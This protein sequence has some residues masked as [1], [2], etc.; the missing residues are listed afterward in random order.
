[1]I[2]DRG[3]SVYYSS[4]IPDNLKNIYG[5][6]MTS[7]TKSGYAVL[8]ENGKGTYR[9]PSYGFAVKNCPLEDIELKDWGIRCDK[10]GLILVY[11]DNGREQYTVVM[12]SN[13]DKK[14]EACYTNVKE[15]TLFVLD[16]KLILGADTQWEKQ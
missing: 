5:T 13:E 10:K 11:K 8:L 16:N 7:E 12:V 3:D 4:K 9:Y 14:F 15:A 2:I 1:M 6:Y